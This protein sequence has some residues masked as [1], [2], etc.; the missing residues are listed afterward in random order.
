METETMMGPFFVKGRPE[1]FGDRKTEEPWKIKIS[2]EIKTKWGTRKPIREKIEVDLKFYIQLLRDP[3]L[4]NLI[5]PCIDGV[6]NALFEA[7]K[8][9]RSRWDTDDRWIWKIIGEKVQVENET[10][11]G[12]EVTVK[13]YL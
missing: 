6:G 4:D 11:E 10:N 1:T 2:N 13:R 8:G 5:K 9:G 12:V 3:D 7:R